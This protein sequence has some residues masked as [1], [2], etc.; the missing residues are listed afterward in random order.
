MHSRDMVD[1]K[2]DTEAAGVPIEQEAD[3][4]GQCSKDDA[5]SAAGSSIEEEADRSRQGKAVAEDHNRDKT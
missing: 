1:S 4:S 5:E 2:D 3:W